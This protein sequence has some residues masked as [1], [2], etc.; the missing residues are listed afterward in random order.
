MSKKDGELLHNFNNQSFLRCP[1]TPRGYCVCLLLS[2]CRME[3]PTLLTNQWTAFVAPTCRYP[4]RVSV[5]RRRSTL[6]EYGTV[7]V[8]PTFRQWKRD[9]YRT[10]RTEP[11]STLWWKCAITLEG[12]GPELEVQALRLALHH[13]A[14]G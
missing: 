13:N 7:R 5:P 1:E 11:T 2:P 14:P 9:P 10:F 3:V 8:T 4:F 12:R 6:R